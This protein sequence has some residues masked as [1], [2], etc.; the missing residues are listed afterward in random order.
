M[1]SAALSASA[2]PAERAQSRNTVSVMDHETLFS[3]GGPQDFEKLRV[4]VRRVAV[5]N[6]R[7]SFL[8]SMKK[9]VGVK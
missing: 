8:A 3:Q 1:K 6:T 7:E 2:K 4:G 5:F 9:L